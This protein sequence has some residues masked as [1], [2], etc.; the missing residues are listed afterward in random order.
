[1]VHE[2]L[3]TKHTGWIKLACWKGDGVLPEGVVQGGTT[4]FDHLKSVSALQHTVADLGRLEH[5]VAGFHDDGFTLVLINDTNP[6]L[7][8]EDE[9]E[10][11]VVEMHVIWHRST[12]GNADVRRD[13]PTAQARRDQIA[14]EHASASRGEGLL[15]DHFGEGKLRFE[16]RYVEGRVSGIENHSYAVGRQHG[17]LAA[18]LSGLRNGEGSDG[19]SRVCAQETQRCNSAFGCEPQTHAIPR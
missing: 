17:V 18:I 14:V 8:A 10:P 1:M 12:L 4:H 5:A 13:E 3:A 6:S 16:G 11:H 2:P 7:A 9:L 15:A 19:C